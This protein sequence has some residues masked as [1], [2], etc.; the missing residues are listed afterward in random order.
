MDNAAV[1]ALLN[2][3]ALLLEMRGDNAFRIRAYQRAAET[4][5]SL[6]EP[7]ATLRRRN[8]IVGQPG[9][10]AGIAENIEQ[11]LDGQPIPI[12]EE[13]HRT[14]PPGVVSLLRVGG[15]GP[16]MAARVYRDLGLQSIDEL[17][18]AVRDGRLAGLER[19]GVKTADNILRNVE[20]LRSRGSR[21]PIAAAIP[22]VGAV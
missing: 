10:G 4:V 1:A 22:I 7:L 8:A 9:I 20:A 12:L 2:E 21:L 16:K 19:V 6:S 14:F 5:A 15:V 18:A 13:L 3:I 11:A 17:E